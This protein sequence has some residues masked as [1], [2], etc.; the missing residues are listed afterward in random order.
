MKKTKKRKLKFYFEL[1]LILIVNHPNGY[2]YKI[3]ELKDEY[4]DGYN[5]K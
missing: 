5:V 1:L 4:S 2:K 3:R